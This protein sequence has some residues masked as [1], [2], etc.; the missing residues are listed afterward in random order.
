MNPM[1]LIP[2]M[3]S[4]EQGT[5]EIEMVQRFAALRP[6]VT[7]TAKNMVMN[8]EYFIEHNQ[9]FS[10]DS[11]ASPTSSLETRFNAAVPVVKP[12]KLQSVVKEAV[13]ATQ[14][15]QVDEHIIFSATVE[16]ARN[17][18]AQAFGDNTYAA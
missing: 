6:T 4:K 17:N 18:V 3:G 9:T 2:G 16:A 15:K 12:E 14:Q 10:P 13:T 5:S 1:K 7:A 11:L 8:A